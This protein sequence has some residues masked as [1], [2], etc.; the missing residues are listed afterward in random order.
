MLE[1]DDMLDYVIRS[2]GGGCCAWQEDVN[3]VV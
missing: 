3:T 1:V 2:G